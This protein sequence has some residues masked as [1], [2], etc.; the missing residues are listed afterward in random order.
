MWHYGWFDGFQPCRP[1]KKLRSYCGVYYLLNLPILT[2]VVQTII[3]SN[4]Y[5][6]LCTTDGNTDHG[7][8]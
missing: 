3:Y 6:C 2:I 5:F 4:T 8:F 1:I 7:D